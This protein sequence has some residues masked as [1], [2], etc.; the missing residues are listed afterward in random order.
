MSM[1]KESLHQNEWEKYVDSGIRIN[2]QNPETLSVAHFEGFKEDIAES[3]KKSA[4]KSNSSHN[5]MLFLITEQKKLK[6]LEEI[7]IDS[8][9]RLEEQ[10]NYE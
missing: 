8:S 9:A 5:V 2:V 6:Q 7:I 1:F 3:I 4:L 10:L